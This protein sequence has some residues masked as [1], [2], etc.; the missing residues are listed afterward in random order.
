VFVPVGGAEKLMKNYKKLAYLIAGMAV[1]GLSGSAIAGPI[2]P[3]GSGTITNCTPAGGVTVTAT[4]VTWAPSAGSGLGCIAAGLGTSISTF[5]GGGINSSSSGTISNLPPGGG[6]FFTLT[7]GVDTLNF[8]FVAGNVI[9][10]GFTTPVTTDG[11]C[12]TTTA[13]ALNHSCVV[14]ANSPFLLTEDSGGTLVS[15]V[16]A[17]ATVTD[18]GNGGT[19]F[20]TANFSTQDNRTTAQIANTIDPTSSGCPTCQGSSITD[21]YS[22]TLTVGTPEPATL[23]GLGAGLVL[24]G[25]G[26]KRFGKR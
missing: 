1:I 26:R 14:A 13:L 25:L 2:G 17:G 5:S 12:S 23:A 15:L 4:T 18:T 21:T 7:N 19:S 8:A 9:T 3:S 10:P 16:L 20:Y 6:T 11:I 22:A 24:I